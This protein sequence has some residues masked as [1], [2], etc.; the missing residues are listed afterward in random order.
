M[1]KHHGAMTTVKYLKTCQLALMKRISADRISSLREIDPDL[2]LPR[3]TRSSL[4]RIIPL[5]DRRAILAGNTFV[6]R[7]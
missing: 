3:L 6:T 4:P 5:S 7:Y 2:P 1:K